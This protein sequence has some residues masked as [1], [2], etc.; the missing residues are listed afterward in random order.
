MISHKKLRFCDLFY[1]FRVDFILLSALYSMRQNK[2]K[3]IKT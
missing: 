3:F 1:I 2:M